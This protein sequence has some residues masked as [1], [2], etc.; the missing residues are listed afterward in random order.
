MAGIVAASDA[1]SLDILQI[2]REAIPK[3]LY[4]SALGCARRATLGACAQI[5]P[6]TLKGLHRLAY[7]EGYVWD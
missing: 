7:D 2:E 4:H 1:W 5:Y 6:Q 3:G